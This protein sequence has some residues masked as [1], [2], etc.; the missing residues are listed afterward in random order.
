MN[1]LNV[2]NTCKR[3]EHNARHSHSKL[4]CMHAIGVNDYEHTVCS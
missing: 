3:S 2:H 1:I 4:V